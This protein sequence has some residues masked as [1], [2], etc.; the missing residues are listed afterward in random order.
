LKTAWNVAS[1]NVA[2]VM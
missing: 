1:E 2:V